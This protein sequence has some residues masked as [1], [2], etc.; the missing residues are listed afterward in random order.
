MILEIDP[1]SAIP[2]FEQIRG[3]I[4]ELATSGE[5]PEG[6]RLPTIRQLAGDLGLAAG[7]VARAYREL[8]A[9]G[10]V[11]SRRRH[12]TTIAPVPRPNAREVRV[13][14][15]SAARTYALAVRTLGVDREAAVAA[16]E[17]A[18]AHSEAATRNGRRNEPE[19][20]YG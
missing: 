16:L 20:R 9:S 3:Q 14:L 10:V 5:L 18:L 13:G 11:L 4:T 8:E 19:R 12:G 2:P 7:T 15:A 1:G 6:A 17:G